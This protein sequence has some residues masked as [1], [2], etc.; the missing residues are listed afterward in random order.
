MTFKDKIFI[1]VIPMEKLDSNQKDNVRMLYYKNPSR[2]YVYLPN[3][4]D[5]HAQVKC[6]TYSFFY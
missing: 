6:L 3:K 2:F 1:L 5:N 4:L